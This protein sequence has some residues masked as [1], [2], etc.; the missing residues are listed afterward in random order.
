MYQLD[1]DRSN[2]V[3]SLCPTH[4]DGRHSTEI[5]HHAYELRKQN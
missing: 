5:V 3:A 1:F 2:Y 4:H